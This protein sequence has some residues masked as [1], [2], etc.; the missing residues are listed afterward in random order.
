MSCL[1]CGPLHAS[2]P[3]STHNF[4]GP[5]TTWQVVDDEHIGRV[6]AHE[7]AAGGARDSTGFERI[8]IAAPGGQSVQLI[9][10]TARVAVLEELEV[11]IWVKANRPD[12]QLAAQVALPRSATENGKSGVSA[13][14]RGAKYDR[15]GHWQQLVLNNL[16]KQLAAEIRILRAMPGA[17]IDPR[18]AFLNAV[19][20]IVPGE[21]HGVEVA[22]DDLVVDGV[23]RKL[24]DDIQQTAYPAPA[25]AALGSPATRS[26]PANLRRLPDATS[27]IAAS[28]NIPAVQL[29]GDLLLVGNKPFLPRA[30]RFQ[31]EPLAYLAERG[32]NVVWLNRAPTVEQT[33]EAK[34]LGLWFISQPPHPEALAREGLGHPGD[35][36]IAWYLD[37]A[38]IESD[39]NYARRWADLVREH[40]SVAS[41]PVVISPYDNWNSA[42]KIA[43]VL[44]ASRAQLG[45]LSNTDYDEWLVGRSSLVHPGTPIW[46][47]H[48]TQFGPAVG[49]QISALSGVATASPNVDARHLRSLVHIACTRGVRGF[50]FHS[51]S[52]LN[53]SDAAT[54]ARA[55]TLELINRRL[56]RLEP[57]LASGKVIGQYPSSDAA[58]S[59]CVL[60][61][62]RAQ[63]LIPMADRA[64]EKPTAKEIAFVVPGVSESCQVFALSP[65]ALKVVPIQRVA[66]GTRFVLRPEDDTFVLMTEDPKVVQSLRQH[67]ARYG[68]RMVRLQRDG[69]ALQAVAI[70]ETARR[71][72]QNGVNST[73]AA[74]VAASAGAQL[75]QVDAGLAS[76]RLEHVYQVASATNQMLEQ[77]AAELRG[78]VKA[79]TTPLSNPLSLGDDRLA[80]FAAFEIAYPTL[81]GGNNLLYGGDFEDLGQL[82]QFGW[83][84]FSDAN[85]GVESKAELSTDEPRH[86]TYCLMLQA[87]SSASAQDVRGTPVWID[88]PPVPIIAGQ[89]LEI[90]GW[91]RVDR[92][93]SG[94]GDG[95][96]IVDSLG[97]PDL[98]LAIRQTNGWE[99]FRIIRAVPESSELRVTF[100]L[101]GLGTARLDAVMVRTL[102]QLPP[103]RRLPVLAPANG[104]IRTQPTAAG[105]LFVAPQTR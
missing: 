42:S 33:A 92:P 105:P 54:R 88:S 66:G 24:P 38:A 97:G 58:W 61:V 14:V 59:A 3:A 46:A 17:K 86:G 45:L 56:Q 11:R 37:D 18:E 34:K 87:T 53:E 47:H 102:Q 75:Q 78:S 80:E 98:V 35:R 93:V 103:A 27:A 15:P 70:G 69:A 36:V 77:A 10:P 62:D 49:R 6:L 28:D 31:G 68:D 101:T 55:T 48:A 73:A 16:P 100:A 9:C 30:I 40:D 5:E 51:D 89:V 67:I 81:Q 60:H 71:L 26:I 63:L 23:V 96:Q 79:P 7:C 12:I 2:E 83:Q 82:T 52:P 1:T 21:P 8:V 44:L 4:N 104:T 41:R 32:F 13:I 74:Q 99:R 39:P 76:N 50:V 64:A 91:V 25:A 65:V 84:H 29:Q 22:T 43:D 57:W 90:A 20:L 94:G 85:P 19:V 95:L 72:T